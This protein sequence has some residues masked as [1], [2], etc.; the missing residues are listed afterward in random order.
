M[1]VVLFKYSGRFQ[2]WSYTVSHAQLL[3]RSTPSPVRATQVDVLFKDVSSVCIPTTL[4]DLEILE[5]P[6]LPGADP[7]THRRFVVRGRGAGGLVGAGA[8][9]HEEWTGEHSDPSPLVGTV[10]PLR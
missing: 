5:E 1:R 9:F 8:V 6:L 7:G 3:L 2:W 4:D 10:P